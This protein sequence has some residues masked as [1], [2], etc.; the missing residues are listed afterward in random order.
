MRAVVRTK[1]P[2]IKI[3]EAINT[4]SGNISRDAFWAWLVPPSLVEAEIATI[5]N[6]I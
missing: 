5:R 1:N 6:G 2:A 4:A 3:G